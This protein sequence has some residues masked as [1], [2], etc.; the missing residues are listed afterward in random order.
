MTRQAEY[1]ID[2]RM[3][4]GIDAARMMPAF[5]RRLSIACVT[6]NVARLPPTY[7]RPGKLKPIATMMPH[8][9]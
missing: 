5:L 8:A 2:V 7:L 9:E 3:E 1:A 4:S 6:S